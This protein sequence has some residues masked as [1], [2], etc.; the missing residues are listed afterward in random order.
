MSKNHQLLKNIKNK[1]NLYAG[2]FSCVAMRC[3]VVFCSLKYVKIQISLSHFT[4]NC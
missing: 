4:I 1:L 3:I 2:L